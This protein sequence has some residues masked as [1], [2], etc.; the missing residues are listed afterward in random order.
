MAGSSERT[1]LLGCL[2]V[3]LL[4]GGIALALLLRVAGV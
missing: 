1:V 4:L 3:S 2:A